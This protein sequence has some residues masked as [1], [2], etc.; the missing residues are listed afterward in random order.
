[1]SQEKLTAL[2]AEDSSVNRKILVH[3]LKKLGFEVSEHENG[4]LAWEDFKSKPAG[5]Y[6]VVFSDIMMPEMDGLQLLKCVRTESDAKDVPFVLLTAVSDKE[7][8]MQ[9]KTHNV[10]G[11]LLK[12]VSFDKVSNKVRQFFPNIKFPALAG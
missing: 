2:V 11:Y 6:G 7:S 10:N 12:P 1:M 8:I 9:A 5:T 4:K 3:I